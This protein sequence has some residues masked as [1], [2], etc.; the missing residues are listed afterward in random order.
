M[1]IVIADD[2]KIIRLTLISMLEEININNRSI[3]QCS[4]GK[5]LVETVKNIKPD[6]VFVDIKMPLLNG[7]EAIEECKSTSKNSKFIITTGFSEFQYAKKSIELGVYEYLLKP[8]E[9]SKLKELINN[10]LKEK[11]EKLYEDNGKFQS[12]MVELFYDDCFINEERFNKLYANRWFTVCEFYLDSN[13]DNTKLIEVKRNLH[14]IEEPIINEMIQENVNIARLNT[15]YK[16]TVF[17]FCSYEENFCKINKYINKLVEAYKKSKNN[18]YLTT[19]IGDKFQEIRRI[20]EE[21]GEL[22]KY[23]SLRVLLGIE[24]NYSLKELGQCKNVDK[25]QALSYIIDNI[26]ESYKNNIYIQ[27]SDYLEKLERVLVNDKNILVDNKVNE[28][29]NLFLKRTI[30]LQ[31]EDKASWKWMT[32]LYSYK[33]KILKSCNKNKDVTEQIM[34]FINQNYMYEVSITNLSEIFDLSPNYISSLFHKK[35]NMKLTDYIGKV[36]I[37]K[38]KKLLAETDLNVDDISEA[39]GYHSTRHY[40]KLFKTIT[41]ISPSE[42]RKNLYK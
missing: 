24:K 13:L 32:E 19:I 8:I 30:N 16:T 9:P 1:K 2:E 10:I 27:F 18:L 34:E 28:N 7:L 20:R 4:N 33:E 15:D 37:N 14:S 29:I 36:R 12:N 26:S 3:F 21:V 31:W 5:E 25:L 35:T 6:V 42:Y 11:E 23:G 40:T 41:G 38:S 22:R 17:I 39:V